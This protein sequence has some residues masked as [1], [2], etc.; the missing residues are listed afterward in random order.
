MDFRYVG[1]TEDRKLVKGKVNASTEEAA[2]DLLSYSGY[3][4]LNLE[5]V[6][7]F[8]ATAKLTAAF[9]KI[10]PNEM[11]MLSRQLALML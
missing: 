3:K 5:K 9:T 7:P 1:Y 10:N 2:L 6:T 11:V 8:L 4:V